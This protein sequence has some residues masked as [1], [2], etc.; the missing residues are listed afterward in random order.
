ML[1]AT[2]SGAETLF[3]N[4]EGSALAK[5]AGAFVHC[6][7]EACSGRPNSQP[8]TEMELRSN[9][10]HHGLPNLKHVNAIQINK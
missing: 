8:P 2:S 4:L 7:V 5:F 1:Q 6:P 10:L 9:F 3:E